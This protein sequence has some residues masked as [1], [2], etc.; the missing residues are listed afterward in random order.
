VK[1]LVL[2]P[3]AVLAACCSVAAVSAQPPLQ[4]K[5]AQAAAVLAEINA[6]DIRLGHTVDAFD[7]AREQ[8]AA[9]ERSIAANRAAL[10]LS[11]RNLRRAQ[12]RLAARI[13]AIYTSDEP[14]AVDVMLGATSLQDLIDRLNAAT[15]VSAQD[16]QIARAAERLQ[17]QLDAR[18]RALAR[19]RATR[20]TTVGRLAA[21]R[22][23]IQRSLARRQRL[24]ASIKGQIA[25]L[26]AQERARERLLAAQA[27]ARIARELAARRAAEQAAARKDAPAAPAL[28]PAAPAA[29]AATPAAPTTTT[30]P[31]PAPAPPSVVPSG[32]H[33]EAA[34]I[35]ARYLGV[36][37]RWGG[38]SPTGF[39][40]SGLVAYVYAQLGISLPHYTVAQYAL[41]VAV[42]RDQLQPGD[43][44]F[45]DGLGHVGI[46]IGGGQFIH[47]PHTGDVVRVSSLSES[48]FAATYVGARRI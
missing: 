31:A 4:A 40:C 12:A 32:G 37:Y 22:A 16:R 27:R 21:R 25:Q 9:T 3:V 48:W 38:E 44:V 36:P 34:A 29:P 35:A 46:Y 41:G 2:A 7:G 23:E 20:A 5:Q 42:A 45:F 26:R 28:P 13:V 11:S 19:E 24:L 17:R 1:R 6:I 14:A 39:D 33:P 43:L 8:L 18:R 15:D 10:R 30:T 47:A